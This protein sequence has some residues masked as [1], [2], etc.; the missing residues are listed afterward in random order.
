MKFKIY[1][2]LA[3][4]AI[5]TSAC[6]D[7]SSD[8]FEEANGDVAVRLIEKVVVISA[9]DVL[10]NK[11][12]TVNYDT[13][14][15]ITNISDGVDS[16]IFV[17]S[18]GT[19]TN[20]TGNGDTFNVEELYDSPYDAFETGEVLEYDGNANPKKIRFYEEDYDFPTNSYITTEYIATI[21]YDNKPNPYFYTLKAGGIIAALD[22]IQLNFSMN[23][24]APQLVQ[25]R[26]MLPV[27]NIN[28]VEYRDIDGVLTGTVRADYVYD[29]ANYPTS[30]TVTATS[31]GETSVYTA[32]YQYK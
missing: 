3:F 19:L 1:T 16:N 30:A 31:D 13:D 8:E 17:Y 4:T 6:N 32:T 24:Q 7:S 29:S 12:I 10:E 9:Q 11:T 25:A 2:L 18:S 14:N 15:R 23:P 27:N 5:L 26:M 21:F 22:A 20:I 28:K